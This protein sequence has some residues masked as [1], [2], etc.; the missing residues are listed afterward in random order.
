MEYKELKVSKTTDPK[1]LAGTIKHYIRSGRACRLAAMG[2]KT[3]VISAKSVALLK[4]LFDLKYTC[5][6]SY[7]DVRK[8]DHKISGLHFVIKDSLI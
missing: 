1:K 5:T 7:F 3:I 4:T 6:I 2:P 8:G